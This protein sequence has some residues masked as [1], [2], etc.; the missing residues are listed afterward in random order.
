MDTS[1]ADFSSN[2]FAVT[3]NGNVQISSAQS[4][5]GGGSAYFDGNGDYLSTNQITLDTQDFTLECWIYLTTYG[6]QNNT[7]FNQGNIDNTGAFL[8]LIGSATNDRKLIFYANNLERFRGA[9]TIPLNTWTNI[10]VTRQSNI[11]YFFINGVLEGTHFASYNHNQTPF[12]IGDGYGGVRYFNGYIDDLRITKGVARYTSNFTPPELNIGKINISKSTFPIKDL[13]AFWKF[14]ENNTT[15]SVGNPSYFL[16]NPGSITYSTGKV[17]GGI[18]LP[19]GSR[20]RVDENLW[21]MVASPTSYSVAF[22]VKK[23]AISPSPQG[24]VIAGSIFGPMNFHFSFGIVINGSN[25]SFENGITYGQ[26]TG[27]TQYTYINAPFSINLGEWIHVVGTYDLGTSTRKLYVNGNL[28]ETQNG[29]TP[30]TSVQHYDWNGFAINGSTIGTNS[31]EYGG[32]HSFDAFGLWSRA[33]TNVEIAAL[34][35]NGNGAEP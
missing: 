24:A 28:I 4:K 15:P 5:F 32:D 23:N 30:P 11:Y 2:N 21:D 16:T 27:A 17:G 3:A 35:N 14:N 8:V 10:T 1:F 7:I 19:E 34:Y 20:I 25:S 13:V 29:I 9:T 22:W 18:N 31:S 33:L 6:S 12:K 26:V